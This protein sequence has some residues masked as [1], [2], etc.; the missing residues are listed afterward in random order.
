MRAIFG[1]SI[2]RC[3]SHVEERVL[4]AHAVMRRKFLQQG[5]DDPGADFGE[6]LGSRET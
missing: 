1:S 3:F 2:Q 5:G 4:H 6:V